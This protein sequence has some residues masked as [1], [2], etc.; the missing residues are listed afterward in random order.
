MINSSKHASHRTGLWLAL[1]AALFVVGWRLWVIASQNHL[2][3]I[4]T[5]VGS[6]A[7]FGQGRDGDL[8]PNNSGTALTFY[9]L[10]ETGLGIYFCNAENGQS[11]LL[12]EQKEKGYDPQFGMLTWSPDDRFFT[13][14]EP[15]GSD[16][17]YPKN[18]FNI[19]DGISGEP[20]MKIESLKDSKFIWLSS[21]SFAYSRYND[22]W[23]IMEQKA[24]GKWIQTQVLNRFT[25]A[26][27][28]NLTVTSPHSVAWRQGDDIWSH[29][30]I[31]GSTEKIWESDTDKL[32][33]FTYSV[34]AGQFLLT[35]VDE[36]GSLAI[37]F[38]P[39]RSEIPRSILSVT[40]NVTRTKNTVFIENKWLYTFY[41]RYV[42]LIEDHGIYS[43]SVKTNGTEV[44]R[45]EW[46]GMV[47]TFKLSGNHLFF[48]GNRPGE[49]PSIWQF[50]INSKEVQ[51]VVPSLNERIKYSKIAIPSTGMITNALGDKIGY[52]LWEPAHVFPGKKYPL[53]IGQTHYDF[54]VW[55]PYQQVAVNGGYYFASADRVSWSERLDEWVPDVKAL[56]AVL[57][58]NPNIDT[59]H[60]F[61]FGISWETAWIADLIAEKPDLWSGAI[62]LSPVRMPDL[63]NSHLARMF[64]ADGR[65]DNNP[66][67][68]LINYQYEAAKAGIPVKLVIQNGVQHITRSIA[69]E[70]ERTRQ[71]AQF[72]LEN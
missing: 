65:D 6:I 4:A 43:F 14:V 1:A 51:Q 13:C 41:T 64:V 45:F 24:D 19:Y 17:I 29:D 38:R 27:L 21:R 66:E 18:G 53:L 67:Q 50:D 34:E 3:E 25:D 37:R 33:G 54:N 72:L 15:F 60:V 32:E 36:N 7:E 28:K 42:D 16:P 35:C 48:T 23:V 22:A 61:L 9:R 56:Y 69:T 10:T 71:F 46:P 39:P 2:L 12:F 70:R 31:S 11:K 57:A 30:F 40:R 8:F 55:F 49:T 44:G 63:S 68:Q 52:H 62:L 47:E 26:E 5:E 20:V 59:N 58:K